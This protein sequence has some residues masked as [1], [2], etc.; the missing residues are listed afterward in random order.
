MTRPRLRHIAINV[1]DR[2]KVAEYYG[3]VF[4]LEEKARGS[5]GT[6]YLSDGFVDVALICN[7]K[8]AWGIRHFGLQ[9]ESVKKI[10]EIAQSPITRAPPES[11]VYGEFKLMDPEGNQID[12][13]EDGWPV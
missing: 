8:R 13:S 7:P 5:N 4:G 1:Q 12:V 2:E 6:I 3:K 10:E 9:V 11:G